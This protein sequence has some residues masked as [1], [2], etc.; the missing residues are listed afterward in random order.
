MEIPWVQDPRRAGSDCWVFHFHKPR[1]I[2]SLCCRHSKTIQGSRK[3]EIAWEKASSDEERDQL[4]SSLDGFPEDHV[5]S[6]RE[7]VVEVSTD[8]KHLEID[9]HGDR[10][11]KVGFR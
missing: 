7:S 11:R 5:G 8:W 3:F 4:L 9:D 1:S 10:L 2:G 6:R